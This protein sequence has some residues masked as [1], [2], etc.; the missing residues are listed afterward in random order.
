MRIVEGTRVSRVDL[1]ADYRRSGRCA[2]GGRSAAVASGRGEILGGDRWRRSKRSVAERAGRRETAVIRTRR[3]RPV[4]IVAP[5]DR[6]LDRRAG[7]GGVGRR[8]DGSVLGRRVRIGWQ[9]ISRVELGARV[10]MRESVGRRVGQIV[11]WIERR[12]SGPGRGGVVRDRFDWGVEVQRFQGRFRGHEV[13]RRRGRYRRARRRRT[14]VLD[15][16]HALLLHDRVDRGC[17]TERR[18]LGLR[19]VRG[20]V[21]MVRMNRHG[22][23]RMVRLWLLWL[24]L[25]MMVDRRAEV[26]FWCNLYHWRRG[27]RRRRDAQLLRRSAEILGLCREILRLRDVVRYNVD[28]LFCK[29]RKGNRTLDFVIFFRNFGRLGKVVFYN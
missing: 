22:D 17:H 1:H 12:R 6:S 15:D 14:V 8:R 4:V 18:S 19:R 13:Q 10:V 23:L 24:V 29:Q 11:G 25:V 2:A 26:N 3:R 20:T 9:R 7:E 21:V 5:G 16:L 27:P 28:Y